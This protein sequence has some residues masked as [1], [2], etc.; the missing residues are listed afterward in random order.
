MDALRMNA[1]LEAADG[2]AQSTA[3]PASRARA[4]Q[5]FRSRVGAHRCHSRAGRERHP[6]GRRVRDLGRRSSRC[7][8]CGGRTDR[9]ERWVL[10]LD[11]KEVIGLMDVSLTP[12]LLRGD[13]LM[14]FLRRNWPDRPI[15]ALAY[16]LCCS[17]DCAAQ[18]RRNLAATRLDAGCGTGFHRAPRIIRAGAVR[19][20]HVGRWRARQPGARVGGA[21]HGRRYCDCRQPRIGHPGPSPAR[22]RLTR[23]AGG[24]RRRFS[25]EATG[26]SGPAHSDAS[27][28]RAGHA[29]HLRGVGLQHQ[30]HASANRP[31][32]HGRRATRP[33]RSA[34][35]GAPSAARLSPGQGSDRRRSAGGGTSSRRLLL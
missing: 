29:V 23:I 8:L 11:V 2:N 27:L 24:S 5:R 35:A 32:P 13:R 26:Y 19:R 34:T 7:R 6:P 28:C 17:S 12:G 3:P 30:H 4:G 10:G 20:N 33:C 18:R 31:Q 16:A 9:F 15:E 22:R 21:S 1:D 25:P 14:D